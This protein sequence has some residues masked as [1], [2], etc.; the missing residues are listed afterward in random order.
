MGTE[1]RR[2]GERV[3]FER[4]YEAALWRNQPEYSSQKDQLIVVPA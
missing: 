4:G 1:Q 3:V 2:F